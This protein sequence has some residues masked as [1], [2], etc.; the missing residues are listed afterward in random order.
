MNDSSSLYSFMLTTIANHTITLHQNFAVIVPH[1]NTELT[2][3]SLQAIEQRFGPY[4]LQNYGVI[5]YPH[6]R[7]A[8]SFCAMQHLT[9]LPEN[10]YV[11]IVSGSERT[12][13]VFDLLKHMT[14]RVEIF[15]TTNSAEAWIKHI[16]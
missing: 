1:P 3:A 5:L 12:R 10:I 16:L 7:Y 15:S 2:A 11:S 4:T 8:V 9:N 6:N 14:N 13:M